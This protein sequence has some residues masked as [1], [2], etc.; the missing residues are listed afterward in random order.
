MQTASPA[1]PPRASEAPAPEAPAGPAA[2]PRQ[3]LLDGLAQAIREHGLQGAKV[4]DIVSHARTSKR[5]FYQ[6][7][8]DKEDCLVELAE[9]WA[10]GLRRAV[11]AAVD[12]EAP[13][14]AQI[15]GAVDAFLAAVAREPA[16]AV[17]VWRD[18]PALGGRAADLRERDLERYAA[19]YRE[20]SRSP[21]MR[22]AGGRPLS[23][24]TAVVLAG[25]LSELLD[26]CVRTGRPLESAAGPMKEA[27]KL[28]FGLVRAAG[29]GAPGRA[30][31]DEGT[32][33]R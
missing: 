1:P 8:A 27:V 25:G 4:T 10:A 6:L 12:D 32:S 3:R 26:R 33:A 7:F 28:M 11:E 19:F 23:R 16:L 22:R 14:D 13:W 29:D 30:G 9:S 18:L 21:A 31:A 5:T 2:T 24:E 17:V 15:D 20:L